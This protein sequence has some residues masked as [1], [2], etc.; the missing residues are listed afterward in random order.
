MSPEAGEAPAA[1][2]GAA[3]GRLIAVVGPSGVG[4]DSLLAAARR[5]FAGHPE[6]LFVRRTITRPAGEDAEAHEPM[7]A[8]AFAEA[9]SAGAFCFTWQAHGLCY[10]LPATLAAHLDAGRPAIVNGSRKVLAEMA[11]RFPGLAVIVVTARPEVIARRL[12][13]RGRESE[14]EIAARLSRTA[15]VD[16]VAPIVAVDNSGALQDGAAAFVAAVERLL[17]EGGQGAAIRVNKNS[18]LNQ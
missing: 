18:P 3:C 16:P 2:D 9:E 13:A 1:G 5:A 12:A 15:E 6:L 10:G 17:V 4:K 7:T 14:G 8:A 11:R